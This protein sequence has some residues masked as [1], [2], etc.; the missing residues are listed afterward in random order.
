MPSAPPP[1]AGGQPLTLTNNFPTKGQAGHAYSGTITVSGGHAPYTW[2]PGS[3]LSPSLRTVATPTGATLTLSGIPDA[4]GIPMMDVTVHDSSTPQ[5]TAT[6][7][8]PV[9]IQVKMPPLTFIQLPTY[10]GQGT[11]GVAFS[12]QPGEV[13]GGVAPYIWTVTG[14]PPGLTATATQVSNANPFAVTG[15]PTKAGTFHF[16]ATVR[17]SEVF[18][19]TLTIHYEIDINPKP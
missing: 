1:S 2:T 5:R 14:L 15:T 18:P 6:E 11:V 16:T 17:D 3:G 19:Q 7:R 13:Q 12:F 4:G 10:V 8:I 9:T